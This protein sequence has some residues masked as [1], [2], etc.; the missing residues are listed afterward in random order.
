[1]TIILKSLSFILFIILLICF[2]Y[3]CMIIH[4]F[5]DRHLKFKKLI[6]VLDIHYYENDIRDEILR[7][8]IVLKN[9]N[10]NAYD[11]LISMDRQFCFTFDI[12]YSLKQDTKTITSDIEKIDSEFKKIITD[13][14]NIYKTITHFHKD[15]NEIFKFT[16][17]VYKS[18]FKFKDY[19]DFQFREKCHFLYYYDEFIKNLEKVQNLKEEE[20]NKFIDKFSKL[21]ILKEFKFLSFTI[22]YPGYQGL[23]I[24]YKDIDRF[25]IKLV[26]E[27]KY[28][29]QG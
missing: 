22:Y 26:E 7:L 16:T 8:Y 5:I 27:Y 20:K 11:V 9:I 15:Y 19:D 4:E 23:Y 2:G 21:S 10:K 3:I 25:K 17:K 24:K 18:I 29:Y 13:Y 12:F 6:E 14:K 28:E 1:M